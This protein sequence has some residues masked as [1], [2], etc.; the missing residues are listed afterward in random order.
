MSI[1]KVYRVFFCALL[2]LGIAITS[3]RMAAAQD[4]NQPSQREDQTNFDTELYLILASNQRTGETP[5]PASLDQVVK[6]LRATLPFKNYSV[7]A[8]LL[9]RVKFNGSLNLSWVGGPLMAPAS[10]PANMP[11]FNEFTIG[12]VRLIPDGNGGQV[13]QMNK[14]TFGSRFPIQTGN[15]II[16]SGVNA[17]AVYNYERTGL[18]TDISVRVGEPSIVGTLN[19]GPSGDAIIVVINARRSQK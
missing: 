5:L 15:T 16:A 9:N 7:A 8:T 3:A 14:F 2:C 13:V 17:G 19:L 10:A 18:T 6:Q 11:T 4:S 1:P 12:Q